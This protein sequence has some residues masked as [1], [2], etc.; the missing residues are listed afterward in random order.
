VFVAAGAARTLGW[1]GVPGT[2]V[3]A[4]SFPSQWWAV[5]AS[6][7]WPGTVPGFVLGAALLPA[8]GAVAERRLGTLRFAAAALAAHTAGVLAALGL[9]YLLR[10]TGGTWSGQ[11]LGHSFAGP[12]AMAMGALTAATAG[13]GPLW[14]R[15]IRLA[16]LASAALLVLYSGSLADM[17][18]LLAAAAGIALGPALHGRAPRL[19]AGAVSRREVRTLTAVAVAVAAVGPVLAGLL[20]HAVGPLALLHLVFTGL[21]PTDPQT[22]KA[23]CADPSQGRDCAAALL[24]QRAG[25]GAVFMAVLPS[26]LLLVLAEGLRRGRRAAWAGALA[27]EAAMA[28]LAA[29]YIAAALAPASPL[30]QGE[31][32]GAVDV[33]MFRN[34]AALVLPLLTPA[35]LTV[36]LAAVRT[37]FTVRAP[38]GAYVRLGGR[39]AFA[40]TALALA[41]YGGGL[42]LHR[43]FSPPPGPAQ[44]LAD[45]PD[46]F[47][48][49][50]YLTDT[51]PAFVPESVPAT[52]LY[53]GTGVGFWAAASALALASFLEPPDAAGAAG[54]DRAVRLLGSA[55]DSTSLSWMT[56]WA[57]NRYWF[58]PDGAGYIAY[59]PLSGV[60]LTLGPP[61]C[62]T[63]AERAAV[64]GFAQFCAA[65]GWT[66]CLYAVPEHTRRA[67]AALGWAAVQV[68]EDAVLDLG[69]LSFAGRRHQDARTALNRGRREGILAQWTTWAQAPLAVREQIQAISEEW[70][71]DKGVPEMG[72]TLG[73]IEE[74]E[75]PA[76]RLLLAIDAHGRVHAVSSWLPVH[77]GGTVTGWTLDF[78]RRSGTGFRPAMEFLI[79]SAA[80]DLKDQGFQTLSLSGA[81]L[82]HSGAPGPADSALDR[83]LGRI[84]SLLEPVYGFRALHAFKAKFGPRWEPLHL[85]YPDPA[86]LP[87]IAG[88]LTRAYLPHATAA[89]HLGLLGR[90]AAGLLRPRTRPRMSPT[91]PRPGKDPDRAH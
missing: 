68:A 3:T 54:R 15:R 2:A 6:A 67:A 85:A 53:E 27:L 22:V 87:A 1:A 38:R 42:V 21:Q 73:G 58:T 36:L 14:R 47:L 13:M 24:Q 50:G 72:F 82:A 5:A 30:P 49:L 31:W 76:V 45:L 18:R 33:G 79:A 34:R 60:A 28:V 40:G 91:R 44:L 29:V 77:A 57:G 83:A 12:S 9:A 74:M 64:A 19:R 70:I 84:G 88:A 23:L 62:P 81:P 86:S 65:N 26:V 52:L 61:V 25:A 59:R 78:M 20:P 89:Q 63:T 37:H 4:H 7:V 75:E 69:S 71:A 43:G 66:P 55:A 51:A 80:L 17:V 39:L 10:A 35:A 32:P 90:I 46:R 48:P 11:L 56:T 41:Y 16:V 8:A